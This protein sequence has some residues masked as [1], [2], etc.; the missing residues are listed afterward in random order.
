[1]S[2]R[3]LRFALIVGALVVATAYF[4]LTWNRSR[5]PAPVMA[6]T[7]VYA[8]DWATWCGPVQGAAQAE[9]TARLD[10]LYGRSAGVKV[11]AAPAV[12][13]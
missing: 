7:G 1:M 2:P 3:A 5:A 8:D 10:A 12:N 4:G 9:C 6:T 13:Y 11:P